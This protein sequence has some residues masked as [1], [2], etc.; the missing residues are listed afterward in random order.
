MKEL[1]L[2]EFKKRSFEANDILMIKDLKVGL[3][4]KLNLEEQIK[5]QPAIADL[6]E[7]G[8]IIYEDDKLN[9]ECLRLTQLG[10]A[11]CNQ[12]TVVFEKL[13]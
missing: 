2:M 13:N 1:I 6:I 8:F 4:K 11:T 10:F 5:F 12:T 3:L 7:E 9:E